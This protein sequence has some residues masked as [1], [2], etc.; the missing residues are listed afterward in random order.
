MGFCLS[1][2]MENSP[3]LSFLNFPA[4]TKIWPLLLQKTWFLFPQRRN[5]LGI[6]M[7]CCLRS[8][9]VLHWWN[10]PVT[11]LS[12]GPMHAT[13]LLLTDPLGWGLSRAGYSIEMSHPCFPLDYTCACVVPSHC[14]NKWF[15]PD[16]W[17]VHVHC[18][19]LN[20]IAFSSN[21]KAC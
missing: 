16:D 7:G 11:K 8:S 18:F 19:L 20:G 13:K 10:C 21:F 3:F 2:H 12:M 5:L 1:L 17:A 9:C 14:E 6:K 4:N 15:E